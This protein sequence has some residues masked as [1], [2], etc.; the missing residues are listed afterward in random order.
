[1]LRERQRNRRWHEQVERAREQAEQQP[2]LPHAIRIR[3]PGSPKSQDAIF[4][5]A[6]KMGPS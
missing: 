1:M 2:P 5:S 6:A 4:D 3:P